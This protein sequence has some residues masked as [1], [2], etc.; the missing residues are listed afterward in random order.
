MFRGVLYNNRHNGDGTITFH[1]S[2]IAFIE[3]N[4]EKLK[5]SYHLLAE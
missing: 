5:I 3:F 1:P 2:G 4:S